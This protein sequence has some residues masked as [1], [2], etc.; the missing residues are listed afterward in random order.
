MSFNPFDLG[1][2]TG[3]AGTLA[4]AGAPAAADPEGPRSPPPPSTSEAPRSTPGR[5]HSS[6]RRP[7]P[8]AAGSL[9]TL[10][11]YLTGGFWG[12]FTGRTTALYNMTSRHGGQFGTLY[13][14]VSGYSGDAN[15]ITAARQTMVREAFKLYEEVLGIN[16]V[17]TTSTSTDGGLLLPGQRLHDTEATRLLH[18]D[19]VFRQRRRD[20]LQHR[21]RHARL[22]R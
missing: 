19:A 8:G 17:E 3:F 11:N 10:A 7:A 22:E 2:R 13:Y 14:N 18:H 6:R 21:Q 15:G 16:F 5:C 9:Q 1:S 20:R 12:D 4:A